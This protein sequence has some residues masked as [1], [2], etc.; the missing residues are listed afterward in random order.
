MIL[1]DTH[2]H[3]YPFYDL[4]QAV[5]CAFNQLESYALALH[6]RLPP[7]KAAPPATLTLFL[8]ERRDCCIYERLLAA[9]QKIPGCAIEALQDGSLLSITAQQE[10]KLLVLP[11]RQIVT[12]ERIEVLALMCRSRLPDGRP[13]QETIAAAKAENAVPV[14][15]WSPGKWSFKRARL[16]ESLIETSSPCELLLGDTP[17]RP[18][19]LRTPRILRYGA[20]LGFRIVAGSDP[21]PM[22]GEERQIGRMITAF[23]APVLSHDPAGSLRHAL[24]HAPLSHLG[25]RFSIASALKRMFLSRRAGRSCAAIAEKPGLT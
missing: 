1:A 20:T 7:D 9:D 16:I 17:L 10:R 22:P 23:E 11:G 25:R 19:C 15:P 12:A 21:L 6:R 14:L 13:A 2:V 5:A 24:F 8:V 18:N 3:L 4:A